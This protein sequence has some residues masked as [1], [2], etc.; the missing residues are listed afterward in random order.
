MPRPARP[1]QY[2]Q[3]LRRRLLSRGHARDAGARVGRH[4]GDAGARLSARRAA[5]PRPR[6]REDLLLFLIVAPAAD[7]RGRAQLRLDGHARAQR[8]GQ[9]AAAGLGLP[10]IDMLNSWGAIALALVHVLLPFMVLSIASTLEGLDARLRGG[11]GDAGRPPWRQFLHVVVP[12]SAHGALTGCLLVFALCMGSFVTVMMMGDNRTMVLPL[13]DLPAAHRRL[14][15]AVRGGARDGAARAGARG[16]P[17]AGARGA[18]AGAM[19]LA[20]PP[21]RD[22]GRLRGARGRVHP[23]AAAGR[24]SRSPS[25][26]RTSSASRRRAGRCAGSPRSLDRS[27]LHATAAR[28]A[29][30]SA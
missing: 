4:A 7:Q 30:C 15:L 12:L 6:P 23:G 2:A 27:D 20:R 28:T 1:R 8:A 19:R 14:R 13:L 10:A 5:R 3:D 11:R 22:R 26:R 18:G 25:P 21:A 16:V 24:R 29:C 17:A 9:R